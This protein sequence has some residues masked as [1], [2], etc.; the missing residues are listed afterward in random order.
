MSTPTAEWDK[1]GDS[2]FRKVQLYTAIFDDDLELDNYVVA[3]ALYSG[4][5]GECR[6]R[7]QNRD[8]IAN[9]ASFISR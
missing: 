4:A 6:A 9:I 5:L 2:F 7:G 8:V 1:I 3:G